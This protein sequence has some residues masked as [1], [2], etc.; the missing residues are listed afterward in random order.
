V[1]EATRSQ[2]RALLVR[3]AHIE[4]QRQAAH[5]AQDW[6]K[7]AGLERELLRLYREH[8]DLERQTGRV[9]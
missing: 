6:P 4:A 7:V 8:A 5:Q 3:A 9:A 2:L 1:N